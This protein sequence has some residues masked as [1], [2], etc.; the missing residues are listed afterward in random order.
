[1]MTKVYIIES[2]ASWGKRI[3]KEK[4]FATLEEAEQFYKD[5]NDKNN[6]RA[7]TP[8]WYMYASLE[9]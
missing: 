5:Y 6:S 9:D 3:D 7:H 4:E 8:T 2:E 1:M